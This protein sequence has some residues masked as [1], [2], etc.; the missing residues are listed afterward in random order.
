MRLLTVDN[1]AVDLVM[2]QQRLLGNYS[3]LQMDMCGIIDRS[4]PSEPPVFRG[5]GL[6]GECVSVRG[7][8]SRC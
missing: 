1:E 7:E 4:E 5:F 3:Q 8:A 6:L 2:V